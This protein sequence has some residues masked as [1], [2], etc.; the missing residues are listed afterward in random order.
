VR[1]LVSAFVSHM[2]CMKLVERS[3]VLTGRVLLHRPNGRQRLPCSRN[4]AACQM[5]AFRIH[6]RR[7]SSGL[8]SSD[9]VLFYYS[10]GAQR[11]CWGEGEEGELR[12]ERGE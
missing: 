7:T 10:A 6:D 5:V 2:T 1:R 8:S 9:H 4:A 11:E 3:D 12:A